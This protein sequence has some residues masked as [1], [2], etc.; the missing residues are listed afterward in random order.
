MFRDCN[1]AWNKDKLNLNLNLHGLIMV[2]ISLIY[3]VYN[4]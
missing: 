4:Q 1:V 3:V 2:F